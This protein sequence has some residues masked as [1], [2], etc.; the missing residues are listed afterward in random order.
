MTREQIDLELQKPELKK[1]SK[2]L[3]S[4]WNLTQD[5]QDRVRSK[6]SG[7]NHYLSLFEEHMKQYSEMLQKALSVYGPSGVFGGALQVEDLSATLKF[8][9]FDEKHLRLS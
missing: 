2:Y 5:E 3:Q 1:Y 8:V 4:F 9:T 6:H 7:L